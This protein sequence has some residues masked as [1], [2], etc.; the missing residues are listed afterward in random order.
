MKISQNRDYIHTFCNDR[1]NPFHFACRQWYSYNNPQC[2]Y[3]ICTLI[4]ILFSENIF[5]DKHSSRAFVG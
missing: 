4:Q 2:C 5:I 3:S 1:S